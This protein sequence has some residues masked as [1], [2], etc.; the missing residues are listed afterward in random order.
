MDVEFGK[1]SILNFSNQTHG[2]QTKIHFSNL[3]ELNEIS[4]GTISET[5]VVRDL[6]ST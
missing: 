3:I 5:G 2:Q 1:V 6:S 4:G